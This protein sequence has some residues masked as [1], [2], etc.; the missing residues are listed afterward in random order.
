MPS[1]GTSSFLVLIQ[2]DY[3]AALEG[4]GLIPI[5]LLVP[6]WSLDEGEYDHDHQH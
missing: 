5:I 1:D 4:Y 6:G 2:H 3:L